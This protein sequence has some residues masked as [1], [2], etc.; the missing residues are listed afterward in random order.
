MVNGETIEPGEHLEM[1][2]GDT[3]CLG[4]TTIQFGRIP[5]NVALDAE[6]MGVLCLDDGQGGMPQFIKER[7]SALPRSLEFEKLSGLFEQSLN[8]NGMLEKLLEYLLDSLPRI[9]NAAILLIREE[10]DI[11]KIKEVVRKSRKDH[12]DQVG[13]YSRSLLKR[14]INDGK[15]IKVS[16]TT[17]EAQTDYSENLD[18]AQTSSTLCVPIISSNTIRGA[19]YLNSVC[20]PYEGFRKED[21]SMLDSMGGLAAVAIENANLANS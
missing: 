2:E 6:E 10:A 9:D 5:V 18:T 3:I 11:R 4:N 21:L 19:I 13:H 20:G 1:E 7:R 8:L 14:L 17:F 15:T 16:N 12:G